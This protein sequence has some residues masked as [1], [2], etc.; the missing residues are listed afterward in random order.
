M[1]CWR[2]SN[3]YGSWLAS[4]AILTL[5]AA[6]QII[7]GKNGSST[8]S[9]VISP[10]GTAGQLAQFHEPHFTCTKKNILNENQ[11]K[12]AWQTIS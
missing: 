10:Q 12:L 2:C 8:F 9:L 5:T 11:V 3:I 6:T 7:I 4:I 1:S